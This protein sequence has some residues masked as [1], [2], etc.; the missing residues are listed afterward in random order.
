MALL[1]KFHATL[2]ET[3]TV[4]LINEVIRESCWVADVACQGPPGNMG[5]SLT[6]VQG[7]DYHQLQLSKQLIPITL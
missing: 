4:R 1:H 3:L 6:A 5:R 2:S 7:F